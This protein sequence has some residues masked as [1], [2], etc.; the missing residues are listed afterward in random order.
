MTLSKSK[1]SAFIVPLA[2]LILGSFYTDG[3]Y[4]LIAIVSFLISASLLLP[5]KSISLSVKTPKF[6]L[7]QILATV[8]NKL[9]AFKKFQSKKKAVKLQT[10]PNIQLKKEL[11]SKVVFSILGISTLLFAGVTVFLLP[12]GENSHI[13]LQYYLSFADFAS[14]YLTPLLIAS[15]IILLALAGLSWKK[16][17]RYSFKSVVKNIAV[18]IGISVLALV[19]GFH[20]AFGIAYA[21]A[22]G[23]VTY[24]ALGYN[25]GI[26]PGKI[27]AD[28]NEI[29]KRIQSG[30]K[31]PQLVYYNY[32]YKKSLVLI[33]LNNY[34][35]FYGKNLVTQLPTALYE[36]INAQ[37]A[38]LLLVNNTI[39]IT[40]LNESALQKVSPAFGKSL[41]KN[42]FKDKNIKSNPKISLLNRQE[43]LKIREEQINK[44][45]KKFDDDI[46]IVN[47]ELNAAYGYVAEGRQQLKEAEDF[48]ANSES[49][50]EAMVNECKTAGE[51]YEGQFYRYYTD[52]QCNSIRAEWATVVSEVSGQLNEIRSTL[53]HNQQVVAD[54][55]EILEYLTQARD[56]IE[57]TKNTTPYELGVFLPEDEIKIALDSNNPDVFN[58]YLSTLVHEYLHYTSYVSEER[59][60]DNFFEE[61]LTEY[62]ARRVVKEQLNYSENVGYPIAVL[63][64]TEMTKEIPED[65]LLAVYLTKNQK[66]LEYLLDEAY[67]KNFYNDSYRFLSTINYLPVDDALKAAN[68]VMVRMDGKKITKESVL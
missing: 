7:K 24:I 36:I 28:T 15:T 43:Y 12:E 2:F 13:L 1:L 4:F 9:L 20:L 52:D 64:L 27:I 66:E 53:S 18:K 32:P 49:K 5:K 16:Y 38:P 37:K 41:V 35:G 50:K 51:M 3:F 10:A 8:K 56:F 60:L 58:A 23:N 44:E 47:Q 48:L 40:E 14:L 6:S 55:Q 25:K 61:A 65:K 22:A 11:F 54:Y 42:T 39:L 33:K 34:K 17:K 67:G 45:V 19:F 63:L 68:T 62:F 59:R 57:A 46:A 29:S 21:Y 30:D 26:V 31:I